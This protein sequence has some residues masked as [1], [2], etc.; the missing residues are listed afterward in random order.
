MKKLLLLCSIAGVITTTQA[1]DY[2]KT[3]KNYATLG[4]MEGAKTELDKV[5]AD[6]KAQAKPDGWMWKAKIYAAFFKDSALRYKYPHSEIAADEAFTKYMQQDTA[7]KLMRD[8]NAT[9]AAFNIYAPAFNNGIRCFTAKLW[10]SAGYYFT[11]AVKYSDIIFQHKWGANTNIAFDTT[12]ILYTGYSYQ[13]AKKPEEAVKFYTRLADNHVKGEGY[14]DIYKYILVSYSNMKNKAQF[15]KYLALSK[16]LYPKENWEDY[17]LDYMNKN[18]TLAEK[19]ALYDKEDAAGTLSATKY[20]HFGDAFAN[21]SK[22][23]KAGLDS[24]K[25][26]GYQRKAAD[27]FKKASDRT[28]DDGI[29]PFN[30]GIIAY[31][32]FGLYDDRM[33]DNIRRLQDMNTNHDVEKDPKKR[34]A[35]EAAFKK[36]L[37]SVRAINTA[38]E[39]PLMSSVEESITWL[40]KSYN[41]LKDK[42]NRTPLEKNCLNKTVDFLSNLYLYKRDKVRGKDPKKY[43]EF[44]AKY[45]VYDALHDKFK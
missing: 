8:M 12:S 13:N 23:E 37:D 2:F 36:Q 1:Q 22:E 16:S 15:D 29:A 9:D 11:Y 4:Q 18:T 42:A 35:A 34:P 30:V 17:E 45:K 3:V 24:L 41:I 31:N 26:D 33:H 32:Q 39:A 27:A 38:M 44:D 40:E 19:A 25:Q 14:D 5:M 21:L 20:L 6:P 28:P 10:D 7:L 43:D